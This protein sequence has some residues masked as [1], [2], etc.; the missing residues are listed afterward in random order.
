MSCLG[1]TALYDV[2]NAHEPIGLGFV[3][4]SL[5]IFLGV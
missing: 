1:S 5:G 4:L 3:G 2:E